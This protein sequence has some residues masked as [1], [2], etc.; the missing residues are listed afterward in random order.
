MRGNIDYLFPVLLII[1]YSSNKI[2][3]KINVEASNLIYKII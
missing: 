1:N 2:K 3:T